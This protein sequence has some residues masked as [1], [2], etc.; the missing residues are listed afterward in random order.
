M[1]ADMNSKMK[2]YTHEM[3]DSI[4]DISKLTCK[5]LILKELKVNTHDS[6]YLY[7][8]LKEMLGKLTIC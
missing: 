2:V 6:S 4:V 1:K 3:E 5:W 8:R 7:V